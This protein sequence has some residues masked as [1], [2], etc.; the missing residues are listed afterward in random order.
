MQERFVTIAD[1]HGHHLPVLNL[2]GDNPKGRARGGQRLSWACAL[3]ITLG[4]GFAARAAVPYTY[5]FR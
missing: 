4:D 3:V 1:T 2:H 5:C